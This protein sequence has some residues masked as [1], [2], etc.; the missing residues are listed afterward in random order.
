MGDRIWG[1][2]EHRTLLV[3]DFDVEVEF[4]D[5][6][7]VQSTSFGSFIQCGLV[8]AN[9]AVENAMASPGTRAIFSHKSGGDNSGNYYSTYSIETYVSGSVVMAGGPGTTD[10]SGK[11]RF[12]PSGSAIST[13]YWDG[14]DWELVTEYASFGS[15]DMHLGL[16]LDNNMCMGTIRLQNLTV[17]V[18]EETYPQEG[19]FTSG[20]YDAGRLVTWT[21]IPGTRRLPAEPTSSFRLPRPTI[22][23]PPWSFWD[24]TR[25]GTPGSARPPVKTS[26]TSKDAIVR[27]LLASRATAPTRP[28]F[29]G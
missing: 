28:S 13:Y 26:R 20:L 25:P 10:T 19:T 4:D 22:R 11:L 9:A 18:P 21:R 8:V 14:S 17:T 5:Y 1:A 16:L 29:T 15:D 12:V 24:R 6:Q 2:V 27:I 7:G 3:R 23:W